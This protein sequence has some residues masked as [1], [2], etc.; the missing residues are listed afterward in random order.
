MGFVLPGYTSPHSGPTPLAAAAACSSMSAFSLS[1]MPSQVGSAEKAEWDFADC[2]HGWGRPVPACEVRSAG[3][4]VHS[5][6][7]L[8]PA[9]P[10]GREGGQGLKPGERLRGQ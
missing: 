6:T 10:L 2:P 1:Q 3:A 7:D 9:D 5:S 4:E 8:A